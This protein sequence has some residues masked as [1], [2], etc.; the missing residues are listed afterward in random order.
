WQN[1]VTGLVPRFSELVSMHK[2]MYKTSSYLLVFLCLRFSTPKLWWTGL[3]SFGWPFPFVA[4]GP[5]R[6]SSP[7]KVWSLCV[8]IKNHE[9]QKG[10]SHE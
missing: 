9:S 10:L 6:F 7:P 1:P 3:G 4:V 8:V 5:T 2:R